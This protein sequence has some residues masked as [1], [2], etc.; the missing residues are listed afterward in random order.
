MK[1]GSLSLNNI[2]EKSIFETN[3]FLLKN[4]KTTLIEYAAFMG[5]AQIVKYLFLNGAKVKSSIWL[6]AVHGDDAEIIHF[7][8]ENCSSKLLNNNSLI[9]DTLLE[10]IKCHH[11]DITNYIQ[12]QYIDAKF[13]NFYCK[14]VL[15]CLLHYYN[16]PYFQ[17]YIKKRIFFHYACEFDYYNLVKIF[18]KT[19]KIDLNE[20]VI[21]YFYFI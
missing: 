16:T 9:L 12:C 17:D 3:S 4:N 2:V 6:Y 7:L 21:S 18:I 19:K 10:S 14:P 11:N 20:I 1:K 15:E 13:S 8:E 5:A